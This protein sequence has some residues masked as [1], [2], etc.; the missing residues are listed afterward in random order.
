MRYEKPPGTSEKAFCYQKLFWPFTVLIN[1][2]SDW[3]KCLKFE[4]EGGEFAKFLI[5]QEQLI[6]TVRGQNNFW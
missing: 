4:A 2:S 3:E 1:C 6:Q 5:S